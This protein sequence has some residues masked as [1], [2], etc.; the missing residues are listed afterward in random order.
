M[1]NISDLGAAIAQTG[2]TKDNMVHQ[3]TLKSSIG[4]AGVGLHSGQKIRITL[5]PAPIDHGIVFRRVDL[6]D[7]PLYPARYDAV[8]DTRLCT[9]LGDASR[10]IKIGTIEHLMAALAGV[11]I[12]NVLIDIDADEVPVMD[13]SSA[14]FN[15]LIDCVGIEEQSAPRQ[16]VEV[17]KPVEVE[18]NG[19][20]ARIEPGH[21]FEIDFEIDFASKAIANQRMSIKFDDGVFVANISRARTFGFLH[22]VEAMRAAG[23]ARGGSLDNAVVLS[24]DEV[25]NEEGLR[26]ED[27]FV[28][29]KILDALGDLYTAGLQLQGKVTAY[30]SG[31]HVNN[32]LLQALFADESAYQIVPMA[33][34]A[35][36][37][38]DEPILATA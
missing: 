28:R 19:C 30:K 34:H 14:P 8:I 6:D 5:H 35:L 24:G 20:T 38:I 23:L 3:R 18:Y 9:C 33:K 21:G 32:L 22:E 25:M 36:N 37:T 11:R 1:T 10:G 15:F 4:C 7:Q 2:G 31:H 13:G 12:D 16:V 27:E 29:H 17:L 26:Y